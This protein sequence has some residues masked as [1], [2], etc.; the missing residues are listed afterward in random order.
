M[1]IS[2]LA[3]LGGIR[4]QAQMRSDLE[5]SGNVSTPEWNQYISLSYKRLYDKLIAAYGNEYSVKAPYQFSITSTQLYA[6]PS[7]FY[8]LLGVDLQYSA[9]PTGW[10]TL[11]R[12]NFIDRNKWSWLNPVPISANLAQL[13]YIPTPT[14]LQF[15]PVCSTT[16]GT[17]VISMAD[18]SD[19]V[20]GM[21]CSS[22]A[23]N[24]TVAPGATVISVN[25]SSTPNTVTISSNV[26]ATNAQIILF[27][28]SD[29]T[30]F[31]GISGW[32]EWVIIDA[33]IKAQIKQERPIDELES[34][35]NSMT[36]DIESMAEGRDA[37]QAMHVSDALSVNTPIISLGASNLRYYL[38]GNQIMFI[39]SGYDEEGGYGGGS[40]G[41]GF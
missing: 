28:W 26:S 32:E 30:M 14:D 23:T 4:M 38:L 3:T 12:M 41:S 10:V 35:R 9:T 33:A 8:K 36:T 18:A 15:M 27:F 25:T 11:K 16:S 5:G 37:G 22:G 19:I 40:Y 39:P 13:W 6:L 29:S 31:A 21:N 1:S 2:S 34:Q 20:V 24:T 7:D 17:S